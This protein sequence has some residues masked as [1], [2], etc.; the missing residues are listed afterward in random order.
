MRLRPALGMVRL[1]KL[2]VWGRLVLIFLFFIYFRPW[3][4]GNAIRGGLSKMGWNMETGAW[5][6]SGLGNWADI[7]SC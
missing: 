6:R 1:C 7:V 4:A 3:S 2:W 5:R